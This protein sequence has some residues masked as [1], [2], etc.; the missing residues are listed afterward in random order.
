[1]GAP[2]TR[3]VHPRDMAIAMVV[4]LLGC[5]C[6]LPIP[7]AIAVGRA[8]RAGEI[9]PPGGEDEGVSSPVATAR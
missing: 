6:L 5:W 7:L 3:R 1:M 4:L 9:E 8:F 2:R